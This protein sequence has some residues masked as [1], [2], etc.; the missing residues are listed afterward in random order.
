M[1]TLNFKGE[2]QKLTVAGAWSHSSL[3]L[4]LTRQ[5]SLL[6]RSGQVRLDEQ[7]RVDCSRYSRSGSRVRHARS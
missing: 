5:M 2:R 1:D 7:S 3:D 6:G 4:L